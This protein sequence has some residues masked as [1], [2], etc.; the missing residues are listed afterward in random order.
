MG[1]WK[2]LGN[3]EASH[4]IKF[5]HRDTNNRAFIDRY[6]VENKESL[7]LAERKTAEYAAAAERHRTAAEHAAGQFYQLASTRKTGKI[8]VLELSSEAV[9]S[10]INSTGNICRESGQV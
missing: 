10:L 5:A 7:A 8:S 1:S 4:S 9:A 6:E 3:P 2:N